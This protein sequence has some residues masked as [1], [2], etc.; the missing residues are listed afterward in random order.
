MPGK[1]DDPPICVLNFSLVRVGPVEDGGTVH[2][3]V[4]FEILTALT[5]DPPN[6]QNMEAPLETGKLSPLTVTTSPPFSLT[7][8]GLTEN[9]V[10]SGR[11][12]YV[13]GLTV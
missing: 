10:G 4:V 8:F 6:V 7:A 3:A 12:L 13:A 1:L 11:Y 2:R 5:T 9:T